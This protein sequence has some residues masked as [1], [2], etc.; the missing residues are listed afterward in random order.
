MSINDILVKIIIFIIIILIG[1]VLSKV[2]SN[3]M[4]KGMKEFEI[5]KILKKADIKF[6]PNKFLPSLSK[7]LIYFIAILVALN[8]V[9]ITAIVIKAIFIISLLAI[10]FYVLISIRDLIPNWYYGIKIKKKYMVGKSINYK[11][12]KGRII[13]MNTVEMQVRTKKEI[14]YISYRLLK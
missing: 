9:G 4:K 2:I 5:S 1:M 6:N 13:H 7:Y 14:I 8:A 10:V 11:N 3:L 12:I